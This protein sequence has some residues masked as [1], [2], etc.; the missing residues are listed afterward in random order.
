MNAN[1]K[2]HHPNKDNARR[3]PDEF[4]NY[5]HAHNTNMP[6]DVVKVIQ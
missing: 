6:T 3:D 4:S 1:Y 2:N 5:F